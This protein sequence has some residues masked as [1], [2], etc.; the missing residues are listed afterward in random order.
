MAAITICSDFGAPQNKSLTLFPLFPHLFPMKWWD[1]VFNPHRLQIVIHLTAETEEGF[2]S[3][4][5]RHLMP[6]SLLLLGIN[7]IT[8]GIHTVNIDLSEKRRLTNVVSGFP[9]SSVVK[10]LLPVQ[11]TH[12]R[13]LVW[14]DL[15]CFWG[16]KPMHHNCWTC[17][18]E[19]GNHNYWAHVLQLLKPSHPRAHALQWEKPQ[20]SEACTQQQKVAPTHC[21]QRKACTSN[22]D[23]RQ[24]KIKNI[25]NKIH[26]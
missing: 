12:V 18:L 10:N 2:E 13:S 20:Q 23:P 14:E 15:M 5:T 16:N 8:N 24:P 1:Q 17:A 4:S 6:C 26:M 19:L 22:K 25:I 7:I 9:S 21:N 3:T 11:E